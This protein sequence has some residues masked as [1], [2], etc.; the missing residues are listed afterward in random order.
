MLMFHEDIK[1]DA[2]PDL[3]SDLD[4]MLRSR[5]LRIKKL[6]RSRFWYRI[7]VIMFTA[8]IIG[9]LYCLNNP[10]YL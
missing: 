1:P 6:L 3:R 7:F 4:G 2:K 5:A 8:I 9:L 10:H